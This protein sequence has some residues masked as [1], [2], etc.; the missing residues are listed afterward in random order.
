MSQA[1]SIPWQDWSKTSLGAFR[2]NAVIIQNKLGD[3]IKSYIANKGGTASRALVPFW[4]EGFF[5][6]SIG[7][8]ETLDVKEDQVTKL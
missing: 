8:C 7:N 2:R 4:D 1:G 6:R 5:Y 3:I